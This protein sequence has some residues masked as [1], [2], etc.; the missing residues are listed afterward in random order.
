MTVNE[1]AAGDQNQSAVMELNEGEISNTSAFIDPNETQLPT[2][3]LKFPTNEV[4]DG[5]NKEIDDDYNFARQNDNFSSP[6]TPMDIVNNRLKEYEELILDLKESKKQ[7]TEKHEELMQL[8][9]ELSY[10]LK[11][12]EETKYNL[13]LMQNKIEQFTV[14]VEQL[15]NETKYWKMEAEKQDDNESDLIRLQDRNKELEKELLHWKIENMPHESDE[16]TSLKTRFAETNNILEDLRI[17][18]GQTK[19]RLRESMKENLALKSSKA[20]KKE[21]E[22]GLEKLCMNYQEEIEELKRQLTNINV[23]KEEKLHTNDN[24]HESLKGKS[25]QHY[26]RNNFD[27][28]NYVMYVEAI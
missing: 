5:I 20:K 26:S 18:H 22:K 11:I 16:F 15:K 12:Y 2:G 9:E 10:H 7:K 27:D 6:K 3:I 8:K 25:K 4:I 13:D 19:E 21:A 28:V 14:Q 1:L 24:K 23:E 17:T